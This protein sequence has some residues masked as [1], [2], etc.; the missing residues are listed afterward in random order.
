MNSRIFKNSRLLSK[1]EWEIFYPNHKYPASM[2]N[3]W[4]ENEDQRTLVDKEKENQFQKMLEEKLKLKNTGQT[5]N[6]QESSND[7]I[8]IRN[9]SKK[10][11]I[12]IIGGSKRR[13]EE[14]LR[15]ELQNKNIDEATFI[16]AKE[17]SGNCCTLII[18]RIQ[19]NPDEESEDDTYV[20]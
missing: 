19:N 11:K 14:I 16:L 2:A 12:W 18:D 7:T 1:E 5:E 4:L 8:F 20:D 9:S 6:H 3:R 15:K 10:G 17:K 13:V